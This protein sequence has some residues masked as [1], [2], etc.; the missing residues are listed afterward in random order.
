M[1]NP[2]QT[3]AKNAQETGNIRELEAQLLMRAAS[4]LQAVK[5]GEVTDNQNIISAVRYNRRLWL[6]FADGLNKAENPLPLEIKKNVS[7]LAM[8]VLNRSRTIETATEMNPERL[9]VL[10][11]IN[12]EIAAGLRTNAVAA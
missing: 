3:Y 9:N 11:N 6:I 10:I 2:A 4:R 8:F 1:A 12:R 5:D 7:R